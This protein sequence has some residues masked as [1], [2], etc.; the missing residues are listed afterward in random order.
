MLVLHCCMLLL[1]SLGG[2]RTI[3]GVVND[4]SGAVVAKPK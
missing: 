3:D 4:P 2:A 1:Q